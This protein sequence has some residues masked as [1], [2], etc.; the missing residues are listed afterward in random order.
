MREKG[1][2]GEI[3]FSKA[4]V[5]RRSGNPGGWFAN[6]EMSGGGPL[7]DIGSHI[8]DL[9]VHL[10]GDYEPVSVFA[11]TFK[12]TENLHNIK[13]H[14]SYRAMETDDCVNDVEEMDLVVI[15]FDN[16]ACLVVETSNVSHIKSDTMFL[17]MLGTKGGITVD[18]KMEIHTSYQNYLMDIVPQVNCT[19][20]D[21]Q[22]AVD[23][24]ISHF[25]DCIK[26][27]VKCNASIKAGLKLMKIIDAAYESAE[28]G[29][30]VE[31]P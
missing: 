29:K 17:E 24:E 5:I 15:N 2:F 22:E 28:K 30:L 16:G 19:E 11:R 25:G 6:R 31:I 9:S 10:M 3:Y 13:E 18:P 26:N 14:S 23:N 20:F 27:H 8:I 21:Y 7:M 4:G 12:K 1:M